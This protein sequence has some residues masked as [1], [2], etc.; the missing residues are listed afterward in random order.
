MI[1]TFNP[2]Q[3]QRALPALQRNSVDPEL[4]QLWRRFYQIDFAQQFSDLDARLGRVDVAGYRLAMQVLRP[5]QALA[6]VIV[7]HGYYDHMGLYG[8]VYDWALRQG[9]AVL[10]CDLPGHGLSSGAAPA[11]TAFKSIS[12]Y[13]KPYWLKLSSCNCLNLGMCLAKA[14]VLRLLLIICSI[15]RPSHNWARRFCW[16]RWCAHAHGNNPSCFIN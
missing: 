8:H 10:S 14:L 9:F 4:A 7:L 13:C 3:L 1:E 12:R 2:E 15:S 11:L 6:T 5:P 16:R